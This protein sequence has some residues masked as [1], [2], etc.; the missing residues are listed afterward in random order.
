MKTLKSFAKPISWSSLSLIV[1]PPLLFF[2]GG[3]SQSAMNQLMMAGT[4]IWFVSAP[5][6]MKPE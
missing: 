4:L 5:F 6:W 1:V 2:T 3:I